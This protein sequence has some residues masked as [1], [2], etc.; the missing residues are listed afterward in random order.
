MKIEGT[1]PYRF[2]KTKTARHIDKGGGTTHIEDR[3][4]TGRVPSLS[5]VLRLTPRGVDGGGMT[6][7]SRVVLLPSM[8][9]AASILGSSM[10]VWSEG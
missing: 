3:I 4:L 2:L 1:F 5:R 7:S 8:A 10:I 6:V 9:E